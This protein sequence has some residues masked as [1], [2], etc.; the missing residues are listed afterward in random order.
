MNLIILI[1]AILGLLTTAIHIF[2]GGKDTASPL[3]KT[4][5]EKQA[6][7]T[8]YSCW[9]FI[10]FFLGL[11]SLLLLLSSVNLIQM[12]HDLKLFIATLWIAFAIVFF[13][14]SLRKNGLPQVLLLPQWTLLCL[15]GVLV[16]FALN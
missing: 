11:S 15:V 14:I 5:L 2:L 9:H 3:L 8:L 4:T 7:Y 10:S 6:K 13:I 12:S 1:A 16:L